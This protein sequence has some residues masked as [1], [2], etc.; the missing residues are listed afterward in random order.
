MAITLDSLT[1]FQT[2]DGF[3]GADAFSIAYS[4]AVADFLW[5]SDVGL[6]LSI[7]RSQL[8][9]DTSVTIQGWPMYLNVMDSTGVD[10]K[11]DFSHELQAYNRG[12]RKFVVTCWAP[13][14]PIGPW[15][16]L[17]GGS[18]NGSLL[19][20][21][22]PDLATALTTYLS[23]A[24]AAGV[25][26]TH[27][28]FM[29]EPD[30]SPS[31]PQTSWTTSQAVSFVKNNIGP[32]LATWVSAN[33]SWQT[34]TGMST[35]G[36]IFG[37]TASWVNN[38]T[39]INAVEADMTALSYVTHYG[40]HQYGGGGASAPPSPCSHPIWEM[41]CTTQTP[42]DATMTNAIATMTRVYNAFVTGNATAWLYWFLEDVS[43]TDNGGLVG[44]NGSNWTNPSAS[45]ADWNS[46]PFPKR[47][48]CLGNLSRFIRP[49]AVRIGCS[50]APA[51]VNALGFALNNGGWAVVCINTNGTTTGITVN[52]NQLSAPSVTPW[53]TDANNNLAQQPTIAVSAGSFSATLTATSVTTYVSN[54]T[55]LPRWM[56]ANA[57]IVR[58]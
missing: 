37:E 41:E 27:V 39:W 28:S 38:A 12:V 14:N 26:A 49:G 2:I 11:G 9:I 4:S 47:A 29:N 5:R 58:R 52:L 46:P 15:P 7:V 40:T 3:G 55:A 33:P 6:G 24:L 30:F 17:S 1:I 56:P 36:L 54:Q 13:P 21:N 32:A 10:I 35:P 16:W 20:G 19:A 44:T 43:D 34:S 23:N 18:Q 31:Y 57:S 22:Y 45:L 48:Y 53:I 51:G 8:W 42:Y 50:G 25:P